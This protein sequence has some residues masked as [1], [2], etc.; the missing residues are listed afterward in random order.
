MSVIAS[1]GPGGLPQLSISCAY[2]TAQVGLQGAQVTSWRPA[3]DEIL[4]VSRSARHAVGEP[5][6]GGIPVA[7][8]QF[9]ELGP[10]PKHGFVQT[11]LWEC[12]D[13]W[14]TGAEFVLR[15]S[16]ETRARWP[17][18]FSIR[19]CVELAPSSLSVH[20]AASNTDSKPW[21]WSGTLHSY[22]ALN[23]AQ[24]AIHGLGPGGYVDRANESRSAYDPS[25]VLRIGRHTDRAY[26]D[27]GVRVEAD[28]GHRRLAIVRHGF[29]DTVVWNPGPE[30]SARFDDL[31]PDDHRSFVCIEAAEMRP[32]VVAPG[33]RWSGSQTITVL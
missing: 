21:R 7:F 30:T 3:G 11:A 8:P 13:Q 24:L 1:T 9:A 20:F 17:H 2:G 4:F 6:R 26:V 31:L 16:E 27:G 14:D 22:F 28:D 33:Q 25:A 23:I 15:D 19:L 32:V 18:R 10:L 12:I 29:R 5:L